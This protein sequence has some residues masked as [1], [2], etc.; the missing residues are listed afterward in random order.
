MPTIPLIEVAGVPYR[1]FPRGGHDIERRLDDMDAT[2]VD[3]H[4][5]SGAPQTWLYGQEAAV[6]VAASI[7]QNDDIA[8]LV[9]AEAGPFFRHRDACRCRRRKRPPRNCAAP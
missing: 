9:K 1:P 6:G 2:E 4:V 7:I 5:L 8:R 3:V